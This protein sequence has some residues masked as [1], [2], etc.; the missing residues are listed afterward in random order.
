MR[1][2]D[3]ECLVSRKVSPKNRVFKKNKNKKARHTYGRVNF[4]HA[5]TRIQ[6]RQGR[7]RRTHPGRCERRSGADVR[8][9]VGVEDLR[10]G[11]GTRR[12]VMSGKAAA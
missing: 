9:I 2:D 12:L 6:I 4:V 8:R 10:F 7:D 1:I 5:E 3:V 11:Q